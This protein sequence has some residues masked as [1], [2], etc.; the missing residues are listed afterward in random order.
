MKESASET[1]VLRVSAAYSPA[2]IKVTFS[3]QTAWSTTVE[4]KESILLC[5]QMVK[6]FQYSEDLW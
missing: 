1:L 2:K 4:R 5:H 6:M 3:R